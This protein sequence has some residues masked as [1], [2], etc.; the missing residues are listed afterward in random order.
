[1]REQ[2]D[3]VVE[4]KKLTSSY[5]LGYASG[6]QWLLDYI[7]RRKDL[8]P[9]VAEVIKC[10]QFESQPKKSMA[11][12]Q[13]YRVHERLERMLAQGKIT[14]DDKKIPY[15]GT[16]MTQQFRIYMAEVDQEMALDHLDQLKAEMMSKCGHFPS[17]NSSTAAGFMCAGCGQW[18]KTDNHD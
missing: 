12:E 1:M 15:P 6:C 13:G 9:H 10:G 4:N 14:T 2:I 7:Q 16:D 3:L 5:V 18:I 8:E 11:E 17:P